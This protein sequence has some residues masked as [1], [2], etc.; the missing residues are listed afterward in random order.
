MTRHFEPGFLSPREDCALPR[1]WLERLLKKLLVPS[2]IER[3]ILDVTKRQITRRRQIVGLGNATELR[4]NRDAL[5]DMLPAIVKLA[6]APH[7]QENQAPQEIG[8]DRQ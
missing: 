3:F 5:F 2:G 8:L 1:Y 7:A 6:R 4:T